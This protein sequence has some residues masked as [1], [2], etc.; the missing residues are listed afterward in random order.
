M[1]VASL[2]P[3]A[4]A[5]QHVEHISHCCVPHFAAAACRPV[6]DIRANGQVLQKDKG[7]YRTRDSPGRRGGCS[8][9]WATSGGNCRPSRGQWS[10]VPATRASGEQGLQPSFPSATTSGAFGP[11]GD[12][13]NSTDSFVDRSICPTTLFPFPF[14]LSLVTAYS[15]NTLHPH[16]GSVS[17]PVS[18]TTS[19]LFPV[20]FQSTSPVSPAFPSP[21]S[22]AF[23]DMQRAPSPMARLP[24]QTCATTST[25]HSSRPSASSSRSQQSNMSNPGASH[26]SLSTAASTSTLKTPQSK[27]DMQSTKSTRT[28][29]AGSSSTDSQNSLET[30][31][32]HGSPTPVMPS[33]ERSDAPRRSAESREMRSPTPTQRSVSS[34]TKVS[35]QP[36]AMAQGPLP[37]P[38][39]T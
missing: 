29:M 3:S 10:S 27:L 26:S 12:S 33:K 21:I 24:T 9:I 31:S 39:A 18:R 11:K 38:P 30:S 17:Q 25:H 36:P 8:R 19:P 28:A 7:E 22:P 13:L 2:T 16:S 14:Q 37:T 23:P 32:N 5:L 35:R 15:Q 4:F 20:H 6:E 1:A 34:T